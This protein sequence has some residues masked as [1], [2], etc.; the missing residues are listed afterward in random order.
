M[1]IYE[2]ECQD[3]KT[4]FT[5]VLSIKDMEKQDKEKTLE[6][7]KCKSKNVK[8]LITVPSAVIIK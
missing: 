3:C 1:P 5:A 6:C 4:R 2:F 8:R 7:P